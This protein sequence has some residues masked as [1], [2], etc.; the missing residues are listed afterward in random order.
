MLWTFTV[1]NPRLSHLLILSLISEPGIPLDTVAPYCRYPLTLRPYHLL[2]EWS[3]TQHSTHGPWEVQRCVTSRRCPWSVESVGLTQALSSVSVQ[4]LN[5][6]CAVC[7]EFSIRI[8]SHCVLSCCTESLIWRSVS[9]F[10]MCWVY[11]TTSRLACC[12]M[13]SGSVSI[14]I[15]M[16]A[17]LCW[18]C[19]NIC[20]ARVLTQCWVYLSHDIIRSQDIARGCIVRICVLVLRV[21]TQKILGSVQVFS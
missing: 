20:T 16:C 19:L 5:S 1:N 21:L 17:V 11:L 10:H 15:S 12:P 4:H 13:F 2:S 9:Y 8:W 6:V 18:V 14:W 3:T 7:D